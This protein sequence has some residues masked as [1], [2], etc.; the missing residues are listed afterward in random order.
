MK[1]RAGNDTKVDVR[2]TSDVVLSL[3]GEQ[4]PYTFYVCADATAPI[5]GMNFQSEYDMYLRPAKDKV[6]I[7]GD[8]EIPCFSPES[9]VEKS[10]VRMFDSYLLAPHEEAILPATVRRKNCDFN[11]RVCVLEPIASCTDRTGLMVCRTAVEPKQNVVPV[12]ILNLTDE[13]VKVWKGTTV[14]MAEVVIQANDMEIEQ[15]SDDKSDEPCTCECDCF[16]HDL[17]RDQRVQTHCCHELQS[18][19]TVFS[20]Y[21]YLTINMYQT[22]GKSSQEFKTDITI[23]EH[24]RQLYDETVKSMTSQSQCDRL[25]NVLREYADVFAKDANDIGRTNVVKHHIDTGTNRPVHQRCRRFCRS[26]I[27]VIREHVQ[28]LSAN[29]TIRPSNSNWAANPVVV[30]KKSG[31]KRLC[32]D[33]RGLNAVTMNPDSYMLPRI[34]DTLDALSGAKY[35]CTLDMIQGYH[36]VELTE[37]SKPKTAFHAPY[38]NPSQWEYN[39]MPFGLIKAPRTFQRMMDRVIQ[40]LEYETALAY[41]DDVIV[42]GPTIDQTIDRMVVVLTRLRNANLKLKAKKCLLFRTEVNYLGH[43][44]SAEGIKTDP[45]KVE[46]VVNWHAPRTVKQVRAFLG[47]V[48]YYSRFIKD[49]AGIANPLHEITKKGTKFRWES[50][51]AEAFEKLKQALASAPVMAYP[52]S[53]GMFI[54][55]TDASDISAG[56]VLSQIQRDEHG[57]EQEKPIAYASKKFDPRERNYCARRRE[58]LAIVKMVK[59][60]DVYLRGPT[61]LIRTDHAS[62]RYMRTLKDISSQVFRWIMTLEEYSYKLEIRKGTLHC[63][64]DAM[65]RGCHGKGCI[66]EELVLFE[67]RNNVRRGQIYGEEEMAENRE[68]ALDKLTIGQMEHTCTVDTCM[69]QAYKLRPIYSFEELERFQEADSDIRPILFWKR[70]NPN[71]KPKWNPISGYSAA[72]K[73]YVTDWDRLELIHGVLYRK[74]ESKDG[75]I[76]R[77]QLLVPAILRDEFCEKVHGDPLTPHMGRRKTLHALQHSC[78]WY[79]MHAD[80][81]LWIKCCTKCQ[82]RKGMNPKPKAKMVMKRSGEQNERVAMDICGPFL[83]T[84][85]YNNY[86][87]VV[88]DHFSKHT[89]CYALKTQKAEEVA[90]TIVNKWFLKYGPPNE[91]H[92]DQG[93]NFISKLVKEVCKVYGIFKTRTSPYHPEGD[94]QAERFNRSMQDILYGLHNHTPTEWDLLLPYASFAYNGTI[95]E[96]TGF[97]PNFMWFGREIRRPNLLLPV[98][99]EGK[100]MSYAEYA[101]QN[102]RFL[103]IAYATARENLGRSMEKQ[104][105]Y[106]DANAREIQYEPGDLVKIDDHTKHVGGTRKFKPKF[107]GPYY[108]LDKLGDVNYRIQASA[109]SNEDIVHHNRMQPFNPDVKTKKSDVPIPEWVIQASRRLRKEY[110]REEILRKKATIAKHKRPIVCCSRRA[111]IV[112]AQKKLRLLQLK[113]GCKLR[114]RIADSIGVITNTPKSTEATPVLRT[115][116][117]REV[118]QPKRFQT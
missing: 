20:K 49:L 99:E 76:V 34:D 113:R 17:T 110:K 69:V 6:Y 38:C 80:V 33:Y 67:R 54:L 95:H 68:F 50:A 59:H 19:P 18:C 64:A 91:L 55:D 11:S 25:A 70:E 57:V 102:K 52:N 32:I 41:L 88:T 47:M 73:S 29:G 77:R 108:V 46:S 23:P 40:G 12:R 22:S 71:E 82:F 65:S 45:A 81:A 56:A 101:M 78:Y 30:D 109:D 66:C 16:S 90:R 94:G 97:T 117:G 72:T 36:Q 104:K 105:E 96:S 10:T 24:V 37:E 118:R 106:H 27:Q 9:C 8:R 42:F 83:E 98:P 75:L 3:S 35:F 92:T 4:Y 15:E 21:D 44:I 60:F 111:R 53:E 116:A 115:R 31:E 28:K 89:E 48:N 58:L 63:N 2:G 26:H 14:A 107:K 84:E 85:R 86:V 1:I 112:K 87:L 93:A 43:V 13:P 62:L 100:E 7:K 103:E 39:Y 5:L 61:F 79:R 51:Q 74:W 114:P